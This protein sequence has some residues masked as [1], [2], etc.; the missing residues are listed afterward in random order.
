M[1][2]AE[3]EGEGLAEIVRGAGHVEE[4]GWTRLRGFVPPSPAPRTTARR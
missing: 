3:A 4:S 1:M 2:V